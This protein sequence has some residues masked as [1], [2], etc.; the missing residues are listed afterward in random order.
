MLDK[1]KKHL[2]VKQFFTVKDILQTGLFSGKTS[3][4]AFIK[5]EKI[6]RIQISERRSVI[7]RDDLLKVIEEKL[8]KSKL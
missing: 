4:H 6:P 5:K 7:M 2:G 3:V 1:I 8:N